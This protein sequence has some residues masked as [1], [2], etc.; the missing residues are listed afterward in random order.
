MEST[1][2]MSTK[3]VLKTNTHKNELFYIKLLSCL[4]G[5]L[6]LRGSTI[7]SRSTDTPLGFLS[8]LIYSMLKDRLERGKE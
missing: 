4:T 7:T 3:N 1:H 8:C 2:G 6:V 5:S